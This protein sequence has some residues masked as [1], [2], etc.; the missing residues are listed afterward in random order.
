MINLNHDFNGVI[1][2]PFS[3]VTINGNGKIKGFI[4]AREIIDHGNTEKRKR[5]NYDSSTLATYAADIENLSEGQNSNYTYRVKYVPGRQ[6][7]VVYDE[8]YNHTM[9]DGDNIY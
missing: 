7:V 6:C 9:F 2:A 5:F 3:Q 4:M 1:Y 8:F